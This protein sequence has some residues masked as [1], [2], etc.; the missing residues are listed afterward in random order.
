MKKFF[1]IVTIASFGFLSSCDN[2]RDTDEVQDTSYEI[3]QEFKQE[4][5]EFSRSMNDRM[6]KIDARLEE[7]GD[8]IDAETRE[9]MA[10]LR[11]TRD[12]L[13]R[14]LE[15]AGEQTEDSWMDFRTGL[16][17]ETEEMERGFERIFTPRDTDMD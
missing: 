4:R 13:G 17:R 12:D 14:R 15:M 10:E 1:L 11:R 16:E 9:E 5:D 7:M 2:D 6:T 8:D 3:S